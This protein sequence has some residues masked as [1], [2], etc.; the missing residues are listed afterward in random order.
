METW[1][2]NA[3]VQDFILYG[4]ELRNHTGHTMSA[5]TTEDHNFPALFGIV[6]IIALVS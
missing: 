1:E 3:T 4:D 6:A 5:D 2:S